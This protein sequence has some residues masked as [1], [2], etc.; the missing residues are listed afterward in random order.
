MIRVVLVDDQAVIRAGFRILLEENDDITVVG[1]ASGGREAVRVVRATHPD[2]VCMDLRM[3]E[4]DGLTATRQIVAEREGGTPSVL[5][6]TTFDMDADVFGALEAG[7][8]GLVCSP[9]EAALIRK[10]FGDR[11]MLVVP[12]VRPA[13]AE[14]SSAGPSPAA[15]L[16]AA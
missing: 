12:G 3:S 4:G 2:V 14:P 8:D 16:L 7:A 9:H 5:V 6:V 15:P 1:E 10:A 13:G 11:P